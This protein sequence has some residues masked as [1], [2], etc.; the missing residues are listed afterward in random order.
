[1]IIKLSK[2]FLLVLLL[3]MS[4]KTFSQYGVMED[5]EE[6]YYEVYYSF[7]DIGWVKFN[8]TRVI[9]KK[10]TYSCS[11]VLK[12]NDA[13]PFV[14]VNFE[15]KSQIEIK[16]NQLRPIYFEGKE[17]DKDSKQSLITY[18]FN[19]DSGFVN[20]KKVGFDNA[21][22]YTKR[23]NL[24]KIY[25]DGLSVFY[26]SRFNYFNKQLVD[27]PV[28]FNQDIADLNL[29]FNTDKTD[30]EISTINYDISSLHLD[31]NTNY[32]LVFGLTGNFEG[33]FSN[34]NARIPV[35]AKFKVQ[36]GNVTLELKSWKRQN[37]TPPKY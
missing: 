21:I 23:I 29:D 1:M 4:N 5:G 30:V 33:W 26:F 18:I 31:G 7:I 6:L 27:V 10:D 11:A 36:I 3:L 37:W 24:D 8:T 22:E 28:I 2:T 17:I 35:K 12:S 9:G 32:E 34:D 16:D 14:Y 13:L 15:F 19:Y 25:Q 20:I